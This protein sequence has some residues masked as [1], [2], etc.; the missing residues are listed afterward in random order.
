MNSHL[1]FAFTRKLAED[2]W[3][4]VGINKGFSPFET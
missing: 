4:P 3:L 1:P 2:F